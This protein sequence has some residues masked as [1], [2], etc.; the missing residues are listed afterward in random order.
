MGYYR[1]G[2]RLSLYFYHYHTRVTLASARLACCYVIFTLMKLPTYSVPKAISCRRCATKS[3]SDG[4][5]AKVG[6]L[7]FGHCNPPPPPRSINL[8]L[9]L[10][11]I[12]Y[13]SRLFRVIIQSLLSTVHFS[14]GKIQV[15][16]T[17]GQLVYLMFVFHE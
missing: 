11:E 13:S 15:V 12:P 2:F 14:S 17:V 6:Q 1:W 4:I 3:R 10:F 5:S 7:R 9:Q 8:Q 16:V